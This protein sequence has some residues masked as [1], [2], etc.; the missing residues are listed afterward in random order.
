MEILNYSEQCQISLGMSPNW[1]HGATNCFVCL[2]RYS[3]LKAIVFVL[4]VSAG[5]CSSRYAVILGA[6]WL[7]HPVQGTATS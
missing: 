1:Q 3:V 2:F 6:L 7:R 4:R 5:R